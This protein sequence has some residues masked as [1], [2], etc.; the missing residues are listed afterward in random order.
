MLVISPGRIELGH[1]PAGD[2]LFQRHQIGTAPFAQVALQ[3]LLHTLALGRRDAAA[4]GRLEL[5]PVV[6]GRVV[7]GGNHHAAR[8]LAVDDGIADGGRGGVGAGQPGFHT[9]R[10][11]HPRD[12][13]GVAV[14]EEARV[15]ADNHRGVGVVLLAH[16]VGD[17][18]GDEAQVGKSK[19]FADDG[20]PAVGAK[21]DHR[22]ALLGFRNCSLQHREADYAVKRG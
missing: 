22:W 18:L 20:A 2:G 21:F 16:V 9:V 11:H 15:E 10:S 7:A 14:R 19:R 8:R 4:K 5:Y 12:L 6:A 3:N 1:Q 13:G 17:G